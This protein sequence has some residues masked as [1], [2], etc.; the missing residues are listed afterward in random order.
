MVAT[1]DRQHHYFRS[2]NGR[3]RFADQAQEIARTEEDPAGFYRALAHALAT[4]NEGHTTLVSSPEVPFLETVPPA[5]LV[6]A[7]GEI[8][9]AGAAPGLESGGLAPGDV[10]GRDDDRRRGFRERAERHAS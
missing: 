5:A 2:P 6:E 1:L 10:L 4:L 8:V 7:E 3:Q 9:V